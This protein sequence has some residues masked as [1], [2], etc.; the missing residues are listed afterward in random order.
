M[1][2]ICAEILEYHQL[3]NLLLIGFVCF[4]CYDSHQKF[5]ILTYDRTLVSKEIIE[6]IRFFFEVSNKFV[7]V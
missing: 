3:K 5:T 7:M 1:G 4:F 2:F 6:N